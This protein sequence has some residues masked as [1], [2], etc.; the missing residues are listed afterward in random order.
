MPSTTASSAQE[1]LGSSPLHHGNSPAVP[2]CGVGDLAPDVFARQ[3]M[4]FEQSPPG[5]ED[6]LELGH[7]FATEFQRWFEQF[8]AQQPC[9]P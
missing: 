3:P 6:E 1:M 4:L 7:Y 5:F 9:L 2:V 8:P